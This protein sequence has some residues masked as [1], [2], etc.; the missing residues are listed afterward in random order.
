MGLEMKV[1]KE[2]RAY[3][4]KVMFGFSWRQ[5]GALAVMVIVGG[6]IFAAITAEL[7]FKAGQSFNNATTMAMFVMVIIDIPAGAWGWW[8]PKGLK[9]EQ[10][11]GY[12]LR[13]FFMRKV[14]TYVDTY[15]PQAA[16]GGQSESVDQVA[17]AAAQQSGRE[18]RQARTAQ[19]RAR[20]FVPSERPPRQGR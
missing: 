16:P 8:R 9:P 3:E 11:F 14:I 15:Q 2:I 19:R 6:G 1:Y 7:V 5:L 20:R 12:P 13:H 4:A 18:R 10:F 17:G